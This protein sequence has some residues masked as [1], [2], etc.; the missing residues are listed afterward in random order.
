V[1][2]AIEPSAIGLD[3]PAVVLPAAPRRKPS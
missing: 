1:Q 2:V 3:T